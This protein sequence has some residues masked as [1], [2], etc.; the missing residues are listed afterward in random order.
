MSDDGG[1]PP[2]EAGTVVDVL[3]KLAKGSLVLSN[4]RNPK[5]YALVYCYSDWAASLGE[6]GS[7]A[8]E[9]GEYVA[10]LDRRFATKLLKLE[11][12]QV[13]KGNRADKIAEASKALLQQENLV[14]RSTG[15]KAFG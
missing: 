3:K 5:A 9:V 15:E 4:N 1:M 10:K 8:R 12:G 2:M 14:E 6:K 11:C 7:K 13:G